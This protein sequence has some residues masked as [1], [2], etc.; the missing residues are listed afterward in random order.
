MDDK[1]DR[2]PKIPWLR[3]SLEV[4]AI[5]FSILLAF[6]IDAWWSRVLRNRESME[7][8][9][10]LQ[11]EFT[12]NLEQLLEVRNKHAE[13]AQATR[14]LL[15]QILSGQD[16]RDI[17]EVDRLLSQ[18]ARWQTY[19]PVSGTL[20]SLLAS[21]DL[22]L[23][24]DALLQTEL[25]G[26]PNLVEDLNEDEVLDGH[27]IVTSLIPFLEEQYNYRAV[28]VARDASTTE[29]SAFPRSASRLLESPRFEGILA[30]R[31]WRTQEILRETD[32]VRASLDRILDGINEA[33]EE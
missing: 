20:N 13:I 2:K 12:L 10:R 27:L 18:L 7:A 32:L 29:Q 5:V 9:S 21:G 16:V 19:D 15:E 4:S 1:G 17:T 24:P 33:I 6:S 30:A 25:A 3:L 14:L 31:L 23:I 22:D 28:I 26:W 11:V 8:L